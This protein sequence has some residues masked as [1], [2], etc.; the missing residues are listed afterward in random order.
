MTSGFCSAKSESLTARG[1]ESAGFADDASILRVI[2]IRISR[3]FPGVLLRGVRVR[4]RISGL[5]ELGAGEQVTSRPSV[6]SREALNIG[7][8]RMYGEMDLSVLSGESSSGQRVSAKWRII[9]SVFR[10]V[11]SS[12]SVSVSV[13][14]SVLSSF[15]VVVQSACSLSG[16]CSLLVTCSL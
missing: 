5:G 8:A 9:S 6:T 11:R 3:F 10:S 13:V 4:V 7:E 1:K 14:L 16:T 12:V 15:I 2:L